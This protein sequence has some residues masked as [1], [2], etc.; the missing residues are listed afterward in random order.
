[1]NN[2]LK[3][4]QKIKEKIYKINNI[5]ELN[6]I[7]VNFLGKKG[8]IKLELSKAK[9]I[10]LK[11]K[12]IEKL[13]EINILKKNIEELIKKKKKSI[14]K[15]LFQKNNK[16]NYFD[17]TL[18]GR[19]KE[20]GSL[21]PI[22]HTINCIEDFFVMSGFSIKTG[23]EIENKYFNFDSLNIDKNHPS[24][25]KTDSFWIDKNFLLRTQMSSIQIRTI[26]NQIPPIKFIASGRVYRND[27]DKTHTP[28][29]HQTEGIIIDKNINFSFLKYILY[30]FLNYFFKKKIIIR[31]RPSYFPFTEPSAEIDI[32]TKEKKW[33]EIL[34]CGIIHPKILNHANIDQNVYSGLAFGIGIER[35]AMLKYNIKD[36]RLFFQN[37]I[38][39]L[40]Q[41]R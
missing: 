22:T 33:L 20:I 18:E 39:F 8:Y 38:S 12:K 24:R 3:L 6:N 28:M 25:K 7:R 31:F 17:I 15:Y 23:S 35:L 32:L 36:L 30:K 21:H 29:F 37:H 40:K 11:E 26:K 9:E 10:Q 19:N 34:G 27:Y 5:D 4:V 1:M 16:I 2:Y 14:K 41:F 13:K